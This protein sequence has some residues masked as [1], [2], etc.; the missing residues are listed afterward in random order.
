MVGTMELRANDT[1]K[2]WFV[3][4]AWCCKSRKKS[5]RHSLLRGTRGHC[6]RE[7]RLNPLHHISKF[8]S[9]KSHSWLQKVVVVACGITSWNTLQDL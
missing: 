1:A 9:F 6:F 5:N 7:K 2:A 3:L 4:T 8:G